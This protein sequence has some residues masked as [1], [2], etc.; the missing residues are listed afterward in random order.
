MVIYTKVCF[1]NTQ[2]SGQANKT[3]ITKRY[4]NFMTLEHLKYPIGKFDKPT[5]IT[6]RQL[7]K[8]DFGYFHFS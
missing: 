1:V 6:K 8:M 5:V 3:D 2:V 7:K 4:I